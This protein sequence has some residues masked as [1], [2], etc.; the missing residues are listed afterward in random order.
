MTIL[1]Q[2]DWT[3]TYE[4]FGANQS[5]QTRTN[6]EL[7]ILLGVNKLFSDFLKACSSFRYCSLVEISNKEMKLCDLELSTKKTKQILQTLAAHNYNKCCC[8]DRVDVSQAI[9][10]ELH[11]LEEKLWLLFE[12][13][14]SHGN[15]Y[16]SIETFFADNDTE[17]ADRRVLLSYH[18]PIVKREKTILKKV[19]KLM[20]Q[21]GHQNTRVFLSSLFNLQ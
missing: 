3:K 17:Y 10:S 12:A 19:T 21:Q 11:L 14:D 18:L 6:H 8:F 20:T 16:L 4:V 1:N 7:K 13:A 9:T 5:L 2:E 15:L